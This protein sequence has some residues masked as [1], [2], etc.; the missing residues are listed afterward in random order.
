MEHDE[1]SRR[2]EVN[3]LG[4]EA[5]RETVTR[6]RRVEGQVRGIQRMIEEDADCEQVLRQIAA[7]TKALRRAGVS[8]AAVGLEHCVR[9]ESEPP[10]SERFRR[11]FLELA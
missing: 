11:A 3:A 8:L 6:L 9:E 10:D 2:M 5:V 4:P 7:A 1:E